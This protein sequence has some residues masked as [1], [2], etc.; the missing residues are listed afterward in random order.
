MPGAVHSALLV[1]ACLTLIACRAGADREGGGDTPAAPTGVASEGDDTGETAEVDAFRPAPGGMRRL[2]RHQYVG[3]IRY[4]LGEAA[5]AAADPPGDYPLHG[6]DAI[7]AAE[8]ALQASAIAQCEASARAVA[9]AAVAQRDRLAEHVPCVSASD[10]GDDCYHRVAVELGRLAWRRPLV[11]EE[12]DALVEIAAAG[13]AWDG[14]FGT[15]LRYELMA[16]LESPSFLYVVEVGEPAADD[17]SRRQLRPLELATRMSLFLLG[18][19][20]DAALLAAAEAGELATEDQVRAAAAAMLQRPEA[21]STL[22]TFYRELL[23]LRDLAGLSKDADMFPQFNTALAASMEQETLRLIEEIVWE[24]DGDIRSL[25]DARH[26]Y[27]DAGL[28]ALYGVPAPAEPGMVAVRLPDEQGRA[29]FLGH[30][31]FLARLS[32]PSMT[33]PTRRGQFIRTRLLCEVILPPPPG[34]DTTLPGAADAPETMKEKLLRHMRDPSCSGCHAAMDPLGLA[35]ENYDALGIFRTSEYG[36]MIDASASV[37]DLGEFAGAR[38]L[39]ARLVGDRR[40]AACVIKNFVRGGLGHIEGP[41]ELPIVHDL[42][43]R[44]QADGHR[45]QGLLVELAASPLFR[46]VGEPK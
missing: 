4:L 31:S 23:L 16:M 8:L 32:H 44:F 39:A 11:D 2:L 34:I 45:V 25:L 43:D 5:A 33:S 27:V 6:F 26:T 38:E 18:R 35:L 14:S 17:P 37:A 21:R 41:G 19:T 40:V 22:A 15:G 12:V 7:G 29:G 46:V 24:E 20:P 9:I 30:A 36:L 28:A 1:A 13:R 42:E 10:P 3:S